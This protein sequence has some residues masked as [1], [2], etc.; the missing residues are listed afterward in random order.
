M[1]RRFSCSRI[2]WSAIACA[3][4]AILLPS[5]SALADDEATTGT[6]WQGEAIGSDVGDEE[7]VWDPFERVNRPIFAFNMYLDDWILEPVATA[8]D[9]VLPRRVELSIHHFFQ[10]LLMPVR[11]GNDLLQLKLIAALDDV[12]RLIV[13]SSVGIAGLFDVATAGGIPQHN[14][15]FGQTLGHWGVPAGPYLMLPVLGPSNP[16]DTT[17]LVVDSFGAV[18]SF[19]ISFWILAGAAVVDT[20][21]DRALTL[22]TFRAEKESAFDLYAAV[23]SGYTQFRENQVRDRRDKAEAEEDEEDLY[24]FEDEEDLYYFED[25]EE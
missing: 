24:Y 8:W 15:D 19:F 23:R 2:R 16:R 18:Q 4:V 7:L 20:V 6:G 21:N 12:G 1:R 14:E 5:L 22:E 3:L 10:N 11:I 25:E 13:N 17:G 9:W